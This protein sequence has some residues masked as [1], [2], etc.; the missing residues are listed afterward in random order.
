VSARRALTRTAIAGMMRTAGAAAM[1][2][3]FDIGR[4]H[5]ARFRLELDDDG[6]AELSACLRGLYARA[7]LAEEGSV[8]RGRSPRRHELVVLLFEDVSPTAPG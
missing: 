5:V 2:G 4:A 7:R 8:E 6:L 1:H 3:G